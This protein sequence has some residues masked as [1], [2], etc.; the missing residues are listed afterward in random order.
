MA[1]LNHLPE[2]TLWVKAEPELKSRQPESRVDSVHYYSTQPAIVNVCGSQGNGPN[3]P[4]AMGKLSEDRPSCYSLKCITL[5]A[6]WA[7]FLPTGDSGQCLRK[8]RWFLGVLGLL[9]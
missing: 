5:S 4:S 1:R 6:L 3:R 7:H 2:V 8:G 9:W